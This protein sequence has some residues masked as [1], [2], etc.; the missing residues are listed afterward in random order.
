MRTI[1]LT[2]AVCGIAFLAACNAVKIAE[3]ELPVTAEAVQRD[4][5]VAD[6]NIEVS[7]DL[8][9]SE[10]NLYFPIAD[11]VWRAEPAGE[12]YAQVERVFADGMGFGISQLRGSQPVVV[13]IDV[14]RFHS[15]TEKARY[16]VGGVHSIKF[17]MTVRDAAMGQIIEPRRYIEADF[18]AYGGAEGI[19]AEARGETQRVRI[20]RHLA[21]V[22]QRELMSPTDWQS[23]KAA[24]EVANAAA[25]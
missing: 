20:T 3:T 23:A 6:L 17:H 5:R 18:T 16:S 9:V 22:I 14:T 4:Y 19:A 12:R 25:L 2:F 15:L 21:G 24:M 8:K 11:I 7:R 1:K 10:A 13:D